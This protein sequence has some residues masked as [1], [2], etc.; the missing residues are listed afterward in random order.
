MVLSPRFR[1]PHFAIRLKS[2]SS[3][4]SSKGGIAAEKEEHESSFIQTEFH[5]HDDE[6]LN[7]LSRQT[8]SDRSV[9]S[10]DSVF[11]SCASSVVTED[12]SEDVHLKCHSIQDLHL[13]DD[14]CSSMTTP[15]EEDEEL[16]DD[17]SGSCLT[18]H[19]RFGSAQ[20]R[21]YPQVLGDHPCCIEGCSLE[22][23]WE[24]TEQEECLAEAGGTYQNFCP[25]LTPEER[26][27]II[28]PKYSEQC[29]RQACRRRLA[30][31]GV[32]GMR[33]QKRLQQQFFGAA[34]K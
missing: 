15:H 29:I 16:M 13:L 2:S 18:K 21:V 6:V 1:F 14:Q 11:S 17:N 25:R 30:Q 10:A 4:S 22:L 3:P 26:L 27:A 5:C 20:F 24:F 23:D 7:P 32:A 12:E 34:C 31:D 19:V 33:Q 9:E 28:Q 8:G